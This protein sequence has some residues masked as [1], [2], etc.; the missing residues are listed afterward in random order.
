MQQDER[1][2]VGPYHWRRMEKIESCAYVSTFLTMVRPATG[3]ALRRKTHPTQRQSDRET[4][5]Q[6]ELLA[7]FYISSSRQ[8]CEPLNVS[9]PSIKLGKL[10]LSLLH[11]LSLVWTWDRQKS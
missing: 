1:D 10:L 6:T 5:L 4:D 7:S 2:Q 9:L 11:L 3:D 8:S